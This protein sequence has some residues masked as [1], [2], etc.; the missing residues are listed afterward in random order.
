[1]DCSVSVIIPFFNSEK[2]LSQCLDSINE[3]TLIRKDPSS[4]ELI[5]VNDGSTDNSFYIAD[6]FSKDCSC[7]CQVLNYKKNH[8][9]SY[10]RN[11][12]LE[13]FSGEYV[14]FVDSD[15]YIDSF[16]LEKMLRKAQ[17]TDSDLV[18]CGRLGIDFSTEEVIKKQIPKFELLEGDIWK[19]PSIVKRTGNL[20][21]DKLMKSSIIKERQIYFNETFHHAEDFLFLSQFRL[22][23]R[24]AAAVCEPLYFYRMKNK[25]SISSS[26]S[27]V[28]D[29]PQVCQM[30]IDIYQTFGAFKKTYNQLLYVMLGFYIR[31]CIQLKNE[32]S[33]LDQYCSEFQSIF[34]TYFKDEWE[35]V[36]KERCIAQ[37]GRRKGW[38]LY[39]SCV[40][41]RKKIENNKTILREYKESFIFSVVIPV[42]NAEEYIEETVESVVSQSIGF[43]RIQIVLV[44][45]GSEDNSLE[46]CQK[47]KNKYPKNIVL[48]KQQNKGVSAARNAG[49]E[50]AEGHYIN[51]LDSDD[52]WSSDAFEAALSFF[53]NNPKIKIVSARMKYFDSRKGSH[54]LNY[55]FRRTRII[56][57]EWQPGYVQL[58]LPSCFVSKEIIDDLRFNESLSIS[59]DMLFVNQLLFKT[60]RYGVLKGPIYK[61]RKRSDNSSAIDQSKNNFSF[62][63]DTPRDCYK[64]ILDMCKGTKY[65]RYSQYLVMYDLQWRIKYPDSGYLDQAEKKR[66]KD[67]ITFL[68]ERIPDEVVFNQK[69]VTN[70]YKAEIIAL[71]QKSTFREVMSVNKGENK[72]LYALFSHVPARMSFDFITV[73]PDG[74]LRMEG[75]A[76]GLNAGLDYSIVSKIEYLNGD[77]L[78]LVSETYSRKNSA[79]NSFFEENFF[80]PC[81]F[82]IAC[83]IKLGIKNINFFLKGKEV[84]IPVEKLG[85][86]KFVQLSNALSYSSFKS[87]KY[88]VEFTEK[89]RLR[90]CPRDFSRSVHSSAKKIISMLEYRNGIKSLCYV[91][92]ARLWGILDHRDVWLVS[93]RIISAG[94]N[95]Q[96]LF[97]Y[98]S[99]NPIRGV[100]PYFAI[101][102]QSSDYLLMRKFGKVVPYGSLKYKIL[103]LRCKV[104]VSSAA[105]E[106]VINAFGKNRKIMK[107][108]Y[109]FK[110]VFLQHGITKDDQTKWLNRFNKNISLVV[111]AAVPEYRSFL[112]N[113]E[114]YYTEKQVKLL[115]FP[116]HDKL[117]DGSR[118]EDKIIL[119]MPTWREAIAGE[120][121]QESGKRLPN[122]KFAETDYYRNYND[123]INDEAIL[124]LLEKNGYKIRF[125]IH[126]AFLQEAEKF[127]KN[128]FV[129][130]PTTAQNYSA[131]FK[132][133]ALLITDYSS[134]AFDFALLRKPIIY[135][136]FDKEVFFC[137]HLYKEGYFD[138]E[139]DGFGPVCKSKMEIISV[140]RACMEDNC[141]MSEMYNK[142]IDDFFGKQRKLSCEQVVDSIVSLNEQ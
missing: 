38:V 11:R 31:K 76:F 36:L 53:E 75:E 101:S 85:F 26:N 8:G 103:F 95:G 69:N 80:I 72:E 117:L 81:A 84:L 19:K 9:P 83:P 79:R 67:I 88:L 46:V 94:D 21:C 77:T 134:V 22:Y 13:V 129:E 47:L 89:S 105:D 93:D 135:Y 128:S 68:L 104:V 130:I 82:D 7:S 5:L 23:M 116:R 58:S 40:K 27:Y 142:R 25:A 35:A 34:Q 114:Y 126:P 97:E 41:D 33:I 32:K 55:K 120:F 3:Q 125:I 96:A 44:D 37:F 91:V 112:S 136:Q 127:K 102:K 110:F 121:D 18:C 70:E 49:L 4:V 141:S 100:V 123:L 92:L 17:S 98:L 14:I 16:M 113:K 78:E 42:Y 50:A 106:Y 118:K 111:T 139:R 119:I 109:R 57:I 39:R 43:E 115:G 1:M 48:I 2:T 137:S 99:K 66:Y 28:L 87:E 59:E 56:D 54:P 122:K 51:F 140:L 29:I 65:E 15:D 108:F 71:K 10:A 45:D 86:R 24:N 90:V 62:Y 52:K 61:Y 74:V 73:S 30:V 107:C 131:E 64:A 124:K 63:F 133:A 20:L 60:G 12:A 132:R 6:S 138:Y